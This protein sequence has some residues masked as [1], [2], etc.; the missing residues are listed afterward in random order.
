MYYPTIIAEVG[1]RYNDAYCLV[2]INDAGQQVADILVTDL[3]YENMFYTNK[4]RSPANQPEFIG[5]PR[6][7]N[8]PGLRTT[9]STKRIGCNAF[10][11]LVE[12]DHLIINDYQL[13]FEISTFV[14]TKDSFEAEE[15]KNDDLVMCCVLFA[16]LTT[17][18]FFK[19]LT[20][21]DIRRKVLEAMKEDRD[22]QILPL[23]VHNMDDPNGETTRKEGPMFERLD[24][25]LWYNGKKTIDD[26]YE[27]LGIPKSPKF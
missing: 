27:Y 23:V 16:W 7:F 3:E 24:G 13:I 6:A 18:T 15:G 19:D 1:K 8:F 9:K 12:L 20:N 17:Q 14:M 21:S 25:D 10:K 22:A 4:Q 5:N 11:T 2:E 26:V